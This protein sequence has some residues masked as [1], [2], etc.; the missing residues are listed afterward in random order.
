MTDDVNPDIINAY[1]DR[2]RAAVQSR[3]REVRL[4]IP[5]AQ[6]LGAAIGQLLARTN[7]L[8]EKV[9]DTQAT[10]SKVEPIE[11]RFDGGRF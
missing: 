1:M 6:E 11:I 8:L 3:S 10:A 9:V 2:V 5:E 4:T 7:R